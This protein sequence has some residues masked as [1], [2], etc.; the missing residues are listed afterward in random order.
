MRIFQQ[1]IN[2]KV[3]NISVKELLSFSKQ[4]KV[5]L[6]ED[7]ARKLVGIIRER[8]IDIYNTADRQDLLKKVA[9]VTNYETA[10]KVQE[11]FDQIAR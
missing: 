4:Y 1:I 3:N 9:R 2:N 11:L 7:Q 5:H 6:T 8:P 10:Q